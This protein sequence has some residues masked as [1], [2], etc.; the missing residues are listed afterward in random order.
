MKNIILLS[1][2]AGLFACCTNTKT[3]PVQEDRRIALRTDTVNI[4]ALGDTL[5]IFEGT[6]RGCAYEGSTGFAISD[7]LN[8]LKLEK[9]ITIDNNPPDMDGGSISMELVIVPVQT[10]ITTFKLYKF[11]DDE[12][13]TA[14]DSANFKS[15]TVRIQN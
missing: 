14:E 9:I 7:S 1:V 6:C 12:M 4:A 11:W 10:G 13:R 5:V 2:I 15:Y 8:L 3:A